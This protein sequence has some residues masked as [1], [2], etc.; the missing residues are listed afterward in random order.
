MVESG[1]EFFADYEPHNTS[2]LSIL[3][4][5]DFGIDEDIK[6]ATLTYFV[7]GFHDHLEDDPLSVA[8]TV[9]KKISSHMPQ[10]AERRALLAVESG[11]QGQISVSQASKLAKEHQP[12][13]VSTNTLNALLAFLQMQ[14]EGDERGSTQTK[15]TLTKIV[16][17]VLSNNEIDAQQKASYQVSTMTG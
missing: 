8:N 6:D 15:Q 12:V 4:N 10:H 11:H 13:A 14:Y 17:L 1:N 9:Q 5:L 7:V 2:V 3:S 16:Q